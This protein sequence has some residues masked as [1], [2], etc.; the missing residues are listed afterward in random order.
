MP[1][2]D[3]Y[4]PIMLEEDQVNILGIAIGL[5]KYA[6]W[7]LLPI[8]FIELNIVLVKESYRLLWLVCT[9]NGVGSVVLYEYTL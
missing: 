6:N 9:R 5:I 2:N 3:A 1:E 8:L 4:E 7:E